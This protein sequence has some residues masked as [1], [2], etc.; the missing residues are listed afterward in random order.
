MQQSAAAAHGG[1]H[2]TTLG[3]NNRKFLMWTFLAS[4]C[5][6]FG[7][8]IATFLLYRNNSVV[9][10]YPHEVLDIPVTSTSTFVLLT[11]SLSMVLALSGFQRGNMAMAR[12]WLFATALLGATFLGF[13][14]FEFYTFVQESLTPRTNVFGAAFFTLTGFHGAHVTLGVIWLFSLLGYSMKRGIPPERSLD[15]ELA[16]LY[17]HFVDIVWIVIFTVVYLL[18]SLPPANGG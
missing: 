18:S 17:W 10:P 14:V 2:G 4:D 13:Q 7:A 12:F 5:P 1:G 15:V 16:G 6:F 9:G 11:S 8:L 3:L